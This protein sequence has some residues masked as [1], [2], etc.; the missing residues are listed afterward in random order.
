MW[1]IY[2]V[3]EMFIT[4]IYKKV[5]N[6]FVNE[7]R[8]KLNHGHVAIF[9]S[10]WRVKSKGR[11]LD[12]SISG[13]AAYYSVHYGNIQTFDKLLTQLNLINPNLIPEKYFNEIDSLIILKLESYNIVRNR[14]GYYIKSSK[15]GYVA[16]RKTPFLTN[17][18][19]ISKFGS[20][21]GAIDTLYEFDNL[22]FGEVYDITSN[23]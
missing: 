16:N 14:D 15:G 5:G 10:I 1:K 7:N 22:S 6:T 20:L 11:Y 9:D 8:I 12:L 4:E 21:K 17:G 2:L 18:Y 19:S 23:I 3:Y 13:Y